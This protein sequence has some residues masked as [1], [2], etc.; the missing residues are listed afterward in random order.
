MD[1][2]VWFKLC[3]HLGNLILHHLIFILNKI[4]DLNHLKVRIRE[5]A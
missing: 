2:Q 3:G 1:W 4:Q 5:L